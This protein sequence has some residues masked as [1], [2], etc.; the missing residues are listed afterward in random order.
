MEFLHAAGFQY[1]KVVS[2][3]YFLYVTH[4]DIFYKASAFLDD[5]LLI[6][7]YSKKLGIV[8]G[9]FHQV[10]KKK[11]GTVCAEADVEWASVKD[12]KPAKLPDEFIVSGL[13][14]DKKV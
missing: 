4:I 12:G 2:L 14:P 6:E 10:V 13:K 8:R 1:K 9:V 3:G 11:D 7:V 5:E